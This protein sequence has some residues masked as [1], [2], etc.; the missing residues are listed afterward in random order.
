MA[1]HDIFYNSKPFN[2]NIT[3]SDDVAINAVIEELIPK[4][5]LEP[6][7]RNKKYLMVLILNVFSN[8]KM[9]SDMWTQFHSGVT[10]YKQ[11][12]RYNGNN[13]SKLIID[14]MK[15]MLKHG[16]LIQSGFL[17]S[18]EKHK[19]SYTARLKPTENFE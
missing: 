17:N 1:W 18:H 8:W 11:K 12:S 9:K 5:K 4:I 15:M 2:L 19:K 13:I 7:D 6:K 14:I 16:Y 10:N 3:I